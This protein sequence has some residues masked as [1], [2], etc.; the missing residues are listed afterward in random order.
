MESSIFLKSQ[1]YWRLGG[2][3]W[4][5]RVKR[6]KTTEKGTKFRG[7]LVFASRLQIMREK[8]DSEL[9]LFLYL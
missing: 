7:G 1:R 3:L 4:I 6:T 5:D 9:L 8:L 2:Q